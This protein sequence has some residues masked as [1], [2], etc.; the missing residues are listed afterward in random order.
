[1]ARD[2]V[3][4]HP[5]AVPVELVHQIHEIFRLPIPAGGS[6]I[7]GGLVPPG[8]VKGIFTQGHEFHMGIAHVLH[9]GHQGI[10]QFPVAQEAAVFMTPP[11]AGV[12]FVDV[13]GP[14]VGIVFCPALLPGSV[15]PPV[16]QGSHHRSG[17]RPQLGPESIGIRLQDGFPGSGDDGIFI[18]G[19]FRQ[20][21][22]KG[23]PDFP[24]FCPFH[25]VGFR[26]PVIEIP[27]HTDLLGMGSPEGKTD[28][29]F[30]APY[31]PVGSQETAAVSVGPVVEQVHTV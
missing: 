7:P 1:M 31:G 3:Q 12:D 17:V 29:G 27:H 2:P 4:D 9:I 11:A 5:D 18:Q 26:I 23:F 21:G 20:I 8:P 28:T 22:N 13:H 24:V 10:R 30:P 16:V 14:M 6:E 25:R 15:P 19:P